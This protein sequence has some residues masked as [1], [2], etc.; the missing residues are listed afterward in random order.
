[1]PKHVDHQARRAEISSA[2]WRVIER[3]GIPAVTLRSVAAEAGISLGVLAHYF[4]SKDD[5]LQDAHRAAYDRT[6]ERVIERTRSLHGLQ[7]LRTSLLEALPLDDDRIL[8]ARVDVALVGATV[9]DEAIRAA[10]AES[11]DTLRR[12]ILGCLAE[13]RERGDLRPDTDDSLTADECAVLIDGA[14]VL[15]LL[16]VDD[17]SIR[18][19]LIALVDAFIA[20]ISPDRT[21]TP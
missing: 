17:A 20:R 9:T 16:R 19:R 7:A 18:N 14:S 11:A 4:T 12:L 6:L 21:D 10:R 2:T 15:G 13:A 5:I 1:M 3:G 8:E